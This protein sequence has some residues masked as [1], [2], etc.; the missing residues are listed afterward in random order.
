MLPISLLIALT[1]LTLGAAIYSVCAR[2]EDTSDHGGGGES[3]DQDY[4]DAA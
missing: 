1:I 3:H 4:S 2:P